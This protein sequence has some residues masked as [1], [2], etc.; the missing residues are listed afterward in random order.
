ML[1]NTELHAPLQKKARLS[2]P[3]TSSWMVKPSTSVRWWSRRKFRKVTFFG[4]IIDYIKLMFHH[5]FG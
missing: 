2:A 1:N 3:L 5:W 4:K